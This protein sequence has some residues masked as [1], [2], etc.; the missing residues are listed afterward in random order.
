MSLIA[1]A[2]KKAEQQQRLG[3]KNAAAGL[4]P[5][6]PSPKPPHKKTAWALPIFGLLFAVAAVAFVLWT[7]PRKPTPVPPPAAVITPEPVQVQEPMPPA[8][9]VEEPAP[10]E[11]AEPIEETQTLEPPP[12]PPTLSLTGIVRGASSKDSFSLINNRTVREGETIERLTIISIGENQ[13]ELKSESGQ[14]QTLTL[15]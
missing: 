10:E 2:L 8:S 3:L 4:P 12:P 6:T 1:D 13:V 15:N 7:Q 14:N 5:A 9:A 11:T